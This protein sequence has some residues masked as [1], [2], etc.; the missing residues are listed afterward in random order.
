MMATMT[1]MA[2]RRPPPESTAKKRQT[3][4]GRAIQIWLDLRTASA[5][6]AF[7]ASQ[8]LSPTIT[9]V[10]TLSLQEFLKSEGYWPPKP[11]E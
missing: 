8:R 5:L 3:R 4:N 2:K 10:L 6:D 7:I 9:D 11:A 1:V